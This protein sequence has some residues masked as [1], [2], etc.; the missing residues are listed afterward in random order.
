MLLVV[1]ASFVASFVHAQSLAPSKVRL[2][3]TAAGV[4]LNWDDGGNDG[5]AT[6]VK[7]EIGRGEVAGA[8]S[9]I[10]ETSGHSFIDT[11]AVPGQ[12]Y[13]YAVRE[14]YTGWDPPPAQVF[15]FEVRDS[16]GDGWNGS[17]I[18]VLNPSGSEIQ[19]VTLSGGSFGNILVTSS[20]AGTYSFVWHSGSWDSECGFTIYDANDN[21]IYN[22]NSVSFSNGQL[23]FSS[24]AIINPPEDNSGTRFTAWSEE[25]VRFYP[26][27]AATAEARNYKTETVVRARWPIYENEIVKT[28][29]GLSTVPGEANVVDFI[30]VGHATEHTFSGLNL[31]T[32]KEYFVTVKV[33][34]TTGNLDGYGTSICSSRGFIFDYNRNLVDNASSTFFNN[35][36]VRV[37][38]GAN[39]N[40]VDTV[41]FG[42]DAIRRYRVPI[43]LTERG[44]ESRFNAPVEVTI[45]GTGFPTTLTNAQNQV[46]VADEW[47]NEVPCNVTT[48]PSLTSIDQYLFQNGTQIVSFVPGYDTPGVNGSLAPGNPT[49]ITGTTTN[50]A[51]T[52]W[53]TDQPVDLTG[54]DEIRIDWSNTAGGNANGRESYFVVSNTKMGQYNQDPAATSVSHTAT[55]G[56]T[57]EPI[58][59]S[60][61]NGPYYIRVHARRGS[62]DSTVNVYNILLRKSPYSSTAVI[63]ANLPKGGTRNYW[64]FWGAGDAAYAEFNPD[65]YDTSQRAWSQYYSRKL[66]PAGTE[67]L[68]GYAQIIPT[69]ASY[70]DDYSYAFTM[71]W[72]FPFFNQT[73]NNLYFGSNSYLTRSSYTTF[74]NYFTTFSGTNNPPGGMIAPMWC[75]TMS[76]YTYNGN[77][78][79]QNHGMYVLNTAIGEPDD[80]VV[81]YF[82]GNRY[83]RLD[84]IYIHQAVTYKY[85]DIALR[86][87]YLSPGALFDDGLSTDEGLND[88]ENTCGISNNDGTNYFCTT[89]LIAGI[90]KN[91]TSF[92]QYKNAVSSTLGTTEDAKTVAGAG[93]GWAGRFESHVFDSRMSTPEWQSIVSTV[94]DGGGKI[95]IYVRTGTTPEPGSGWSNWSLAVSNATGGPVTTPLTVAKQRYIQYRCEFFKNATTDAPVLDRIEFKCRGLEILSVTEAPLQVSQ[96]QDNIPIKVTMKNYDPGSTA[97]LTHLLPTFTLGNYTW[98]APSPA[99]PYKLGFS[100]EKEF[101]FN[102]NVADDSPTGMA[103]IDANA[104][105]TIPATAMGSLFSDLDADVKDYWEVLRKAELSIAKIDTLPLTVTKGQTV[106]V[107]M[108]ID[109]I[110]GTPFTIATASLNIKPGSYTITIDPAVIGTEVAP[111]GTF[112]AKFSVKIELDSDSGVAT[113]NGAATGTNVLSLKETGT[114]TAIIP[115]SWTVQN[116]PELVIQSVVASD[117]VYRGQTGIP[118]FL[119]IINIGEALAYWDSSK[120]WFTHG[121]YDDPPEVKTV[122]PIDVYGGL[123]RMAEYWVNVRE[124]SATGT[125]DVDASIIYTDINSGDIY[126]NPLIR[127]IFPAAWLIIGEK[128]KVFKDSQMLFESDSF[129][130]PAA[131]LS[132]DVYTKAFDLAYYKEYVVRWYHPDGSEYAVTVPPKTSDDIG[133]VSHQISID[134]N[135]INMGTWRVKVTNPLNTHTACENV[136]QI[137]SPADPYIHI[138][139][140]AKVSVGQT[141]NASATIINSG[142]AVLKNAYPG[143]LLPGGTGAA[144]FV[145]VPDP[146]DKRNI[147]GNSAA[148]FSY[149]LHADTAGAGFTLRGAGYGKDG[150]SDVPLTA[151]TYTSDPCKIQTAPVLTVDSVT[152]AYT[153]VYRNQQNMTVSMWIKNSGE[154]DAVVE[155]ASLSFDA[156]MHYQVV[157]PPT[158]FPFILGGNGGTAN[159]VFT[160]SIDKDSPTGVVNASCS[161]RAHDANN[162]SAVYGIRDKS[163]GWTISAVAGICSANSSFNPQQYSFNVGQTVNARFIN[164]PLNTAFRIRFYNDSPTGGTLV[165]TSPPLNSGAFGV[166]DDQWLLAEV[167]TTI[168]RRWRVVIDDGDSTTPGTQFGFQYFDV[169]NPGNLQAGLTLSPTDHVFVGETITATLVVN[170]SQTAGSTI[171]SVT[172]ALLQKAG[173]AT[174]NASK[175]SGP[176]PIIA[177]ISPLMPGVFTWSYEATEDTTADSLKKFYLTT[178]LP[179]SASGFDLNTGIATSSLPATSNGIYIYR[180]GLDIGSLTIDFATALPGEE[181]TPLYFKVINSGNYPL[182]NVK[183]FTADMRNQWTDYISKANLEFAPENFSVPVSGEIVVAGN[184]LIDHNQASGSYIATMSVYEDLNDNSYYDSSSEPGKLFSVK[185]EVPRTKSIVISNPF[186]DLD[187]WAPGQTAIIKKLHYFN[188]G[189]LELD[190]LKVVQTPPVGSGSFI[191]AS[192]ANHGRLGVASPAVSLDVS[193]SVPPLQVPGIY[194]ATFTIF[195]DEGPVGLDAGDTQTLFAVKIGV[196]IKSF[197]ITPILLDAGIATPAHVLENLPAL[198]FQINNTGGLGLTS[199]KSL[200]GNLKYLT[201]TIATE[202]N[203]A[204]FLPANVAAWGN[205]PGS[206]SLYIPMGTPAGN[207]YLGKMWVYE[208]GNNSSSWDNGEA[209]ASF[210]VKATVPSYSAVQVIPSTVDLGDVAV[211]TG[212]SKT[213]LCRNIGNATLTKL[214]WDKIPLLS[215]KDSIPATEYSFSGLGVDVPPGATFSR[216]VTITKIPAGTDDGDYLGNMAWLFED[217]DSSTSRTTTDPADPQ[218][219]FKVACHVGYISLLVDEPVGGIVTSGDPYSLSAPGNFSILNNGSLTLARPRA[220][221]TALIYTPDPFK[222]IPAS[223]SSFVP[224]SIDYVVAGDHSQTVSWKVQVP[225]GADAGEYTGT[226]TVWNDTFNYGVIDPGEAIDS[227]PL[228]LHVN[229]KRVIEVWP[230]PVLMPST[231]KNTTITKT[232]EI[233][234]RGNIPL[235]YLTGIPV[236]IRTPGGDQIPAASISFTIAA[237]TVVPNGSALATVTVVV[238]EV[239]PGNYVSSSTLPMQIFEDHDNPGFGFDSGI[240]AY[241]SFEL[242]LTVGEKK[243][244][245]TSPVT[246]AA[247]ALPGQTVTSNSGTVTNGSTDI[248][249][250]KLKWRAGNLVSGANTIASECV[251]FLPPPVA[252]AK[253]G[254][255]PFTVRVDV[256]PW[257][258]SA[259]VPPGTYI[260]TH[261][262]WE[263][264]Y[265][266]GIQDPVKEASATFQTVI[267]ASSVSKLNITTDPAG[268]GDVV[269][270]GSSAPFAVTVENV[271]NVPLTTFVWGFT[272]L[273]KGADSIEGSTRLKNDPMPAS[274]NP[275]ENVTVNVWLENIPDTQPVGY[276][277]SSLANLTRLAASGF[278][279][280]TLSINCTVV[281]GGPPPAQVEKHSLFQA[282]AP[283]IF[284]AP[285]PPA[286]DLY[287]LSAWVCPGSGSADLAF[288]QYDAVGVPVATVSLR[289]DKNGNISVSDPH[290][291][292][293]VVES[294]IS[295]VEPIEIE[296]EDGGTE[297][298]R[299][300]RVFM[301]FRLVYDLPD[302]GADSLKI[303]LHNSS[304]ADHH[305]VWFDGIKLERAFEGQT[306]PTTYHPGATLHSPAKDNALSGGHHYYEW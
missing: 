105:A 249:L 215:P 269:Q 53:V 237:G 274:L 116:P 278:A 56:R 43:I 299:Y 201:N 72:S 151:A 298:C 306:R 140:P 301:A 10:F 64:A 238:G 78:V 239:N 261:T 174:G 295:D 275:T 25:I 42:N 276:Y 11:T 106:T 206:M 121:S 57:T 75:D 164:L 165:K 158:T 209:S 131:G 128:I 178:L 223:A 283:E 219:G 68:T 254:S 144:S 161:Y 86:Y 15:R 271:G 81:F 58:N 212:I 281:A 251:F 268:L 111:G 125:S 2:N 127:S 35:A 214:L 132:V 135:P 191:M 126:D 96:G 40:F 62:R 70:R 218:S 220:T 49:V 129:N 97:S 221:A 21:Q 265:A 20:A 101:T 226:L 297:S 130:L 193:A 61:L 69:P 113:L 172:P 217:L 200:P 203:M 242:R 52:A 110:G 14:G 277:E 262:V 141:F 13:Y 3:T 241:D 63:I 169:Q 233:R 270:G 210:E 304:P 17:Y 273:F 7:Y 224:A 202:N 142:G 66:L 87:E 288:I 260:G 88:K 248:N 31:E 234:N 44:I 263:D 154:A 146:T 282:V 45:G 253:G 139:L 286:T 29:V 123:S 136:F 73:W 170:N 267:V 255:Q 163:F 205:G 272:D 285:V 112:A 259:Y 74:H 8:Y 279:E 124:D 157:N 18:G 145:Q 204:I 32:G 149:Q 244:S 171:G 19:Q 1:F 289:V 77:Q 207:Y 122:F 222:S 293:K 138:S 231:P 38:T 264:D 60:S 246:Y 39:A 229:A 182:T 93:Y 34:D 227:A 27:A 4:E 115:D 225:A 26:W 284:V 98:S 71:P 94:A 243:F 160:V 280:D 287:F 133:A 33:Q 54:W 290:P 152:E 67:N 153:T 82:R 211:N 189:N 150:N 168:R 76:W 291:D 147:D 95:Y 208:D 176:V 99:L 41:A 24:E 108:T 245:I 46:R 296:L 213:F 80:R 90:G 188:G 258:P 186:I 194:I 199:L 236:N 177:S 148:T 100:E 250:T 190:N 91:P 184:L 256:L 230:D 257:I 156:G 134:S 23:F 196:G 155:A 232:F 103:S 162:P 235:D 107:W 59:V 50:G 114:S 195:D 12:T 185:V 5:N 175:I 198:Q 92:F 117:T 216:E 137:V 89:P 192:P 266:D 179:D 302:I 247:A 55:F 120:L 83:Q 85:G 119:N 167:A 109:N 51:E 22:V 104:T 183:W 181:A 187:N 36:L 6:T 292:F 173:T 303:V 9:T 180:R 102:I 16:Y 300:Y 47:G 228:T 197:T 143:T 252:V 166:C 240:E 118:V 159:I 48:A 79:P 294:G 30:D 65:R 305:A 37:M 84:D 28:F